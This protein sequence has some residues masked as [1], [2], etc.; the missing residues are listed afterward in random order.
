[1]EKK[2]VLENVFANSMEVACMEQQQ[3]FEMSLLKFK[4]MNKIWQ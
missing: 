3:M 1:M 2:P 4:I